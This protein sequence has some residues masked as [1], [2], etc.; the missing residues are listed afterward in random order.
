MEKLIEEKKKENS[1]ELF[2]IFF[3]AKNKESLEK[4]YNEIISSIDNFG[5]EKAAV[6]HSM[7]NTS[8]Q[9]GRVG[10]IN[11]NRL[12]KEIFE[13]IK[14]LS[15]GSYSKPIIRTSGLL[16]LFVK[17]KKEISSENIDKDLEL[18]K[19][20]SSERNR[21]LNEFSIIHFK[22]TENKS[23]VKEF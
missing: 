8:E 16:I 2:E 4:K 11:Q 22:K 20:I 14:D 12:S 3:S 1:Y 19:I 7:S 17:D 9:G 15:L 23:Y 6:L 21:Q 18:S 10:W 13:S 5:F